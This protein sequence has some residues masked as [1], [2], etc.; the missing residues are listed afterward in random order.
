M[1]ILKGAQLSTYYIGTWTLWESYLLKL[2]LIVNPRISCNP[3]PVDLEGF[4]QFRVF[5]PLDIWVQLLALPKP[6]I[7]RESTCSQGSLCVRYS[8]RG[9]HL[10]LNL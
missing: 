1:H 10:K 6:Q 3:K 4:G 2:I 5:K 8:I 7:T 9:K